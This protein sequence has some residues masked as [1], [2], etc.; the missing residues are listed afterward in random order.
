MGSIADY[1]YSGMDNS[2]KVHHFL[3]GIESPELKAAVDVVCAKPEKYGI[4][5][6]ATVLSGPNGHEEMPDYSVSQDCKNPKSAGE[7]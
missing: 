7:A 4:D 3:E 2:T 5:F 1:S 6:D